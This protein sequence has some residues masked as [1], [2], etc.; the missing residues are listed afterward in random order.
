M[1]NNTA[2][3]TESPWIMM[4]NGIPFH[5]KVIGLPFFRIVKDAE[6][7]AKPKVKLGTI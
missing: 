1:R 6:K 5:A 3:Y 7:E 4:E 2:T